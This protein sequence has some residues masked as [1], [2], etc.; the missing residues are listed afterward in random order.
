[1]A[2][3]GGHE[4]ERISV[5][6]VP[7]TSGFH[8]DT[9]AFLE[10]EEAKLK[11]EINLDL[12]TAKAEA[13]L[14]KLAKD[15][16]VKI[17]VEL[18]DEGI[19]D[20]IKALS[21]NVKATLKVNLDDAVARTE[22]AVLARP[23]HTTINVDVDRGS[24]SRTTG[25]LGRIGGLV[26]GAVSSVGEGLSNAFSSVQKTASGAFS[27]MTSGFAKVSAVAQGLQVFIMG[28]LIAALAGLVV[29]AAAVAGALALALA[30]MGF[31][32]AGLAFA[33]M[34]KNGD[35][36]AKDLRKSFESVLRTGENVLR[37]AIHPLIAALQRQL[38]QINEWVAALKGPLTQA[39]ASAS[40]Y[41]GVLA[42][43]IEGSIS[44]VLDG[45]VEALKNPALKST[46]QGLQVLAS[47]LGTGLGIL[48]ATLADNGK[49]FGDTLKAL[50]VG[51]M[52]LM[53]PLGNLLGA[54][55][56]VSPQ[57]IDGLVEVLKKLFAE[58]SN[59]TI[60]EALAT[61]ANF[62]FNLIAIGIS[63]IVVAIVGLVYAWRGLKAATEATWNF[64]K[65]VWEGIVIFLKVI[66]AAIEIYAHNAWNAIKEA[67][68][69]PLT[70]LKA[71]VSA[72]WHAIQAV[73]G[74]VWNAIK[75]V[76]SGPVH[77]ITSVITGA[78]NRIRSATS[79]V[80]NGIKGV[81]AGVWHFIEG[82]ISKI[83][84]AVNRVKG[85]IDFLNPFS[86]AGPVIEG[87]KKPDPKKFFP[88]PPNPFDFQ[89]RPVKGIW[90]SIGDMQAL[91]ADINQTAQKFAQDNALANGDSASV[92]P[93]GKTYN[94]E[95]NA[96]PNIPTEETIVKGLSYMDAL[97]SHG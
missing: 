1:M 75:S 64:L 90:D 67:V 73:S 49:V 60:L 58:L 80:W 95:I 53:E 48:F 76:V 84:G 97:Y 36:A 19:R 7:D 12:D 47:T 54:F 89:A 78:W 81:I 32:A 61:F 79:S 26:S 72:T 35:K 29:A 93:G 27:S 21:R 3:P 10:K 38:P 63:S 71:F 6:V 25:I 5:K 39:F 55:A 57:I 28:V 77:A 16:K 68:Q 91:G 51:F 94:I 56:G 33:L 11:L 20:R 4:V 31:I 30:P 83:A 45:V 62:S 52:Q 41:V 15:L 70:T 23:R 18:N 24:V 50:G 46:M 96:A 66:W 40:K 85:F 13:Q 22:L 2:G 44:G 42:Q 92:L 43:S 14:K 65:D 8:A 82:I 74:A 86:L 88:D 37:Q 69:H 17:N 9:K 87:P 34:A 59:P